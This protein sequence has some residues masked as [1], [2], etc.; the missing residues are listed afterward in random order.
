MILGAP[1]SGGFV[2]FAPMCS[3]L[4]RPAVICLRFASPWC[5]SVH[6]AVV[7]EPR[8]GTEK[9]VDAHAILTQIWSKNHDLTG[10]VH[11]QT[12]IGLPLY[13]GT[14]YITGALYRCSTLY[15][16]PYVGGL[17]LMHPW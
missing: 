5:V 3:G 7:Q 4:A 14:P 16:Y 12:D 9:R 6:S 1:C 15:R 13:T 11:G 8:R 17:I 2:G 10:L